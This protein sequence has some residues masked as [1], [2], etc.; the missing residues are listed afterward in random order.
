MMKRWLYPFLAGIG[1]LIVFGIFGGIKACS[2]IPQ[3]RALANFQP[4]PETVSATESKTVSWRPYVQ[5][6]GSV[7]AV[8]GVDVS[9]EL[10]GKV[11]KIAFQS[12]DEVKQGALL[13]QLDDSQEQA[14]LRQYQAQE[15]LDNSNFERA[16]AL[17]KKNLNAKQ[18]LD[19]A[20][21]QYEMAQAQVAQEQAVIAKKT[22]RAPFS[23][24]V[25]IRQ[26]NLGQY[27]S[28]GQ[29]IVNIEQLD[30]LYVTF[31]LPQAEM[32]RLHLGQAVA[33]DVD[34]YP[35]QDFGGK[36][37][38]INPAVSQQSRTV[39]VQAT[40]P[41]PDRRLHPGM[42]ASLKVLAD[43]TEQKVVIPTTAISY[44]LYGDSVFVLE[45]ET[46]AKKGGAAPGA[47]PGTAAGKGTAQ[48]APTIYTA[49]QVFVHTGEQRGDLVAVTGIKAGE[50]IVT[51][52]QLKLHNG[53]RAVV[54]N[55]VNLEKVPE[56]TP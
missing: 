20:R 7:T 28:A 49:K 2:V 33:V 31:T 21:E 5:A 30:P 42:F 8:N 29:V 52:G 18:D 27:V 50:L 43:Q 12:G 46:A 26:V 32:P 53:S 39:Q 35:G 36:I 38:A 56:L 54:N 51:A 3:L 34:A 4:P 10:A 16:L 13:V 11:V 22:I 9:S 37:T 41:N 19:N 23:G 17:R 25:G 45:P 24:I 1:I 14:L 48:G 6:I 44:S 15:A 47:A 55:S 40:V